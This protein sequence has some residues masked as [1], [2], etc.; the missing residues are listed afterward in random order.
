M[1]NTPSDTDH[2]R[3]RKIF[4]PAF[5]DRSLT[6]QE[7]L[8]IKYVDKLVQV[9]KAGIRESADGSKTFDMV[10]LYSF[11]T[12]DIMADL[13]FG[14]SLHMLD[15]N[16][17]DPWVSTVFGAI[18]AGIRL[19]TINVHYPLAAKLINPILS[20]FFSKMRFELHETNVARVTKR[21]TT[22]RD[23][24]GVDLWSLILEQEGKGKKGLTRE[25]MDSNAT[26]FMAAGTETT[27]TLLSGLTYLLL[28]HPANMEKLVE[29]IRGAFKE[30]GDITMESIAKLP[31]LKACIN[32][33]FRIYP[34]V[35]I[36]T[37]HLTPRDGSTICGHFVPHGVSRTFE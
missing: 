35:A 30:E 21:L 3:V 14:E 23:A 8:F 22:G 36:G 5:S 19:N 33:A 6:Q 2:A 7:P 13:T 25:Q 26:I 34:P 12:F 32:E 15:T 20:A 1:V 9:L 11:T 10:R 37:P 18:K 28:T 4:T 16:E 29:E 31:Y 17:Y 27:A 24:E